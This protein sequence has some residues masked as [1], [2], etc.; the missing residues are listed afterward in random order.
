[1][2]SSSGEAVWLAGAR[3]PAVARILPFAVY[4]GFLAIG[5][6]L[7]AAVPDWDPRW[8]Y[9]FQ[10]GTVLVTMAL[11]ARAYVELADAAAVTVREWLLALGV[12]ALVFV[13]WI[14][15]DVPWLAL[16]DARGFDPTGRD[17][18]TDWALV[19]VRLVGAAA[20][21]PVMEELFWRSFILRWIERPDFLRQAP[22]AVGLRA[23]LLS[24]LLFG[25]EHRLWFAG[26]V[27]GLA[28]G[29]LYV[30]CGSLWTSIAAHA[31]TNLLLGLWVV[32]TANWQ[33]W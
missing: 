12:G 24:A 20:V 9:A 30:R 16:G 5:Q 28:Y 10:V 19:A 6:P 17:G 29:W 21:V 31:A 15:L 1:M 7:Q 11:F 32:L 22:A 8:L 2:K 3:S 27:A 4:I 23:L 18:G 25:V 33:F 13:A 14:H 26:M